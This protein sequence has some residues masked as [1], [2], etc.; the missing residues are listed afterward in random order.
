[1]LDYDRLVGSI[2]DC[3]ANPELWPL[4]LA[5]I[6]DYLSAEYCLL[7]FVDL[8]PTALGMLPLTQRRNSVWNETALLHLENMIS[9]IPRG[10]LL[11]ESGTDVAWTQMQQTTEEEFQATPFFQKWAKVYGLRDTVSIAFFQRPGISGALS[12][13]RGFGQD[14]YGTD[15][16]QFF[17]RISPHIRRAVQINDMTD[18]GKLALAL[19]RQVLDQLSVAVFVVG[20]GHR[21]LFTNA[22]GDAL[23]SDG[24]HV[25]SVAG[26]LSAQ[27]IIG[28]PSALDDA[29]DRAAKGDTAIGISGIGVPLVGSDGTRSAAYVLPIAGKD[30]RGDIGK[31]HCAVFISTRGEQQPIVVEILRT[32]FDLTPAEARVSALIA[33][34]DGPAAIAEGLRLSINTVR[35]HLARAFSK[36]STSDQ[37][38]LGAL[39]NRLL[40]PIVENND[41]SSN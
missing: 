19:Y 38:A 20:L 18:K 17:E 4:T 35:S 33:Q 3:A 26:A 12:A 8:T 31:G 40:P 24:N 37:T 22:A 29:I 27:R 9:E 6:R 15:E 34:G 21:I 5:E 36:T 39:V 11:F 30:I 28:A 16:A 1:M 13:P 25:R 23:L 32:V 2:Y 10:G 7:G 41:P 14:L